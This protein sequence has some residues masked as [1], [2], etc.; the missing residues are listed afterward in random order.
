MINM[1]WQAHLSFA[2]L[3]F[4]LTPGLGFSPGWQRL[5]LAALLAVSFLPVDGLTLAAYVHS[6]TGDAAI[7]SLVAMLYLA[8]VRTGFAP[9]LPRRASV[10]ILAVMAALAVFLY[11][12]TLGLSYLDPYRLGYQPRPL[13]LVVALLAFALLALKNHLGACMLGL[14]TLAFTVGLK[15][16]PN[17]WDYL[18]DPFIGLYSCCAILVYVT[19]RLLRRKATAQTR[20]P[21]LQP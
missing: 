15:A 1:L 12:A 19:G 7:T 6:F 3:L 5:R 21:S 16:S 10:Q 18:I 20:A 8:G 14:A 2:L 13:I 9:P 11:P 17:Y 4:L